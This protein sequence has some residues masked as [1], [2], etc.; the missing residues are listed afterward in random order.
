LTLEWLLKYDLLE[1]ENEKIINNPKE[2]ILSNGGY[3]FLA[4]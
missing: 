2:F 1:P 4:K 3:I